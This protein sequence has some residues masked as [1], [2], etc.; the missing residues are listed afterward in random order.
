MVKIPPAPPWAVVFLFGAAWNLV[1]E[2]AVGIAA[3]LAVAGVAVGWLGNKGL[4]EPPVWAVFTFFAGL[5]L[6]G[7]GYAFGMGL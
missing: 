3:A 4:R 2:G 7:Y 5:L 1:V 6:V